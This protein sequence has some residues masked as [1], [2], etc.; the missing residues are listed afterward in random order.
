[1]KKTL[2]V[3]LMA[4]LT[5]ASFAATI[6][7]RDVDHGCTLYKVISPDANGKLKVSQ[8]EIIINQKDAYGLSITDMEIDFAN[9][10]VLVQPQINVVFGINRPLTE[11]K[12][13]IS[14]DN[15]EFNFL[16]N[17]LNRKVYLFEQICISDKNEIEYA[18]MFETTTDQQKLK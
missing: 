4:L 15:A 12:A 9:R 6:K 13:V 18:K 7:K 17:Q 10:E 8:G 1:M 14:A 11:K 5:Q 3:M 16:I 2:V